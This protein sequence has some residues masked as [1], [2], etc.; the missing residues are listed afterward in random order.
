[1]NVPFVRN[2]VSLPEGPAPDRR[3]AREAL[4]LPAERTVFVCA[5]TLS[6]RKNQRFLIGQFEKGAADGPLLVLLGDG[7]A[8]RRMRKKARNAAHTRFEG[9]VSNVED[10]LYAA[11]YYVSASR[12][13]G[14]GLAVIEAMR[15]GLPPLLSVTFLYG[16]I[17]AFAEVL[18]HIMTVSR[19]IRPPAVIVHQEQGL[20]PH[21]LG[22]MPRIID[23]RCYAGVLARPSV[24]DS[25]L[26][27]PW[28]NDSF[29]SLRVLSYQGIALNNQ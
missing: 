11:D 1:M 25:W 23:G 2:G 29:Q 3:A 24:V 28:P 14:L 4:G 12:S 27:K 15:C 19:E 22:L 20:E 13:E 17:P 8:L 26:G 9:F 10:Y 5:A 18:L 7:P 16:N 21:L 6:R